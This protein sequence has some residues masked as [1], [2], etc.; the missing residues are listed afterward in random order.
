[1]M[2]LERMFIAALVLLFA[3]NAAKAQT[4]LKAKTKGRAPATSMKI[5]SSN[6]PT[7]EIHKAQGKIPRLDI[8]E[9]KVLQFQDGALKIPAAPKLSLKP[10][11][12]KASPAAVAMDAKDLKNLF[13]PVTAAKTLTTG[14]SYTAAPV[15]PPLKVIPDPVTS[16]TQV[17][18]KKLDPFSVA[19]AKLFEAQI[20]LERQ[21]NPEIALGLLVELLDNKEVQTEARYSYALAARQLG[22]HSEFRSTLMKIALENKKDWS[23]MAVEA[24]ARE[25]EALDFSD[26]KQLTELVERHEI[27]TDKNDAYNFYRAKYFLEAGN[28]G[29]VED[30]LKFIPETSKFRADALLI[31][32]LSAYRSGDID[33]AQTHL[34]IML[35]TIPKDNSLRSIGALTLARIQFQKNKYQE[36]YDTYLQV[37]RSSALFLQAMVEQAWAQILK[38]DFEGAAGNMFSLHTD[39]FKNAFAPETYTVR[40]VAYLNLCQYG[41]GLQVLENLKRRYGPMVG[42]LQK[43]RSEK[44]SPEDYYNTVRNW[45]KNSDLREV[46]GLPRSFIVELARH[47]SFMKAQGTINNFEDELERFNK[48]TLTLIQKEKD[49]L[50]LQAEARDELSKVKNQRSGGKGSEA[51]LKVRL[52]SLESR[53][54]GLK[55]QYD[56]SKRARTFMKDARSRAFARIEKEKVG[57]K[58]QASTTLKKRLESMVAELTHV[59]EQNEVLQ[60][61]ILAGAGEHLRSQSAGAK[62]AEQKRLPSDERKVKWDF[63]GEIWEDEVGH[64]RSSLKNVCSQTDEKVASH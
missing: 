33:R 40:S 28:L 3:A 32:A 26:M 4:S 42:R 21:K 62:I 29:Q 27:D 41:D 20:L 56:L 22:L 9:E 8:G 43:Y 38:E 6:V 11:E 34:E 47:P 63:K 17:E 54:A 16:E 1:M 64:Y 39:F 18:T 15:V 59:L 19:E 48:A 14:K 61:E 45:L 12:T 60:Y 49:F 13:T 37:D 51:D 58:A 24:L 7:F 35:K 31:S 23:K 36:A 44:K 10:V 2:S 50:R 46:D 52:G 25:V 30:A 53:I 5:K 57:L 55:M